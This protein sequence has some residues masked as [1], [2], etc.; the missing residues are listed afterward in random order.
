M[1]L[2]PVHQGVS[3]PDRAVGIARR[4]RKRHATDAAGDGVALAVEHPPQ[5]HEDFLDQT[6]R[7]SRIGTRD[8]QGKFV[9]TEAGHDIGAADRCGDGARHQPQYP[10]A[11]LVTAA[12]VDALEVVQVDVGQGDRLA[13]TRREIETTLELLEKRP[14]VE[15]AG[16]R[17]RTGEF[18]LD[19]D[20][21]PQGVQEIRDNQHE[22]Q[23]QNAVP[24]HE[25]RASGVMAC[26]YV[27]AEGREHRERRDREAGVAPGIPG[28]DA[29]RDQVEDRERDLEADQVVRNADDADREERNAEDLCSRERMQR[30]IYRAE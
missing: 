17:V 15:D 12:V 7:A 18:L 24:G 30:P 6:L 10:V 22:P 19:L 13:I 8:Q 21:G 28:R 9:A 26:P 3:R 20:V 25:P 14:P 4:D 2:D 27:G 5:R 23:V 29:H 11:A 16:Q 1:V